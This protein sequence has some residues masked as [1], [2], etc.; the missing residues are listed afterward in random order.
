MDFFK[1]KEKNKIILLFGPQGSGNHLFSKIFALHPDVHGW[2][3]LLDTSDPDNYFVPHYKEPNNKYWNDIDSITLDIMGGKNYAVISASVPFWNKD[4][5][6]IPPF[7]KFIT[8]LQSLDIE[9]QP[10]IIGRDKT[11]LTKQQSRIRGGPTWGCMTQ[12]IRWLDVTPFYV[13][14]E[15]VYLYKKIYLRD[16]GKW[17]QFPIAYQDSR[18][19]EILAEDSNEKYIKSAENPQVDDIIRRSGYTVAVQKKE[20]F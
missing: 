19:E 1:N 12:Y 13:S 8:K 3:E 2:E 6:Q 4:E 11:I 17:L 10:V 7:T 9:V 20:I 5:L 15:L 14:T 18:L 16:I